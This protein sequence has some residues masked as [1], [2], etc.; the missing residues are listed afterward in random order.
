[1]LLE[2]M[3]PAL[4]FERGKQHDKDLP[5]QVDDFTTSAGVVFCACKRT[6]TLQAR[7][8]QLM[9]TRYREDAVDGCS[10]C[11]CASR[12]QRIEA[13]AAHLGRQRKTHDLLLVSDHVLRRA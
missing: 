5:H 12:T 3:L 10:S 6:T 11:F 8:A 13:F 9:S 2:S 1:M 4:I 7:S